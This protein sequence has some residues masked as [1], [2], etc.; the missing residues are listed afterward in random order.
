MSDWTISNIMRVEGFDAI[1][2]H[3]IVTNLPRFEA[4]LK[5]IDGYYTIAQQKEK[6]QDGPF[7]GMTF[8]FTG[9]RDKA[10]QARIEELGGTVTDAI[11]KSTA[12]LITKTP[13]STGS[14]M[15]KARDLGIKIIG[16]AELS[17]MLQV[18]QA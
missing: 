17:D 12:F 18:G 6:V 10:A 9:Y 11:N 16:P 2:A 8:V 13:Q 14:K 3:T 5:E 7:T 15:K 1:T 4:F